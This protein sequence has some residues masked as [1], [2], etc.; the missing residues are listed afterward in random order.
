M[1]IEDV[2]AVNHKF[3]ISVACIMAIES[4]YLSFTVQCGAVCNHGLHHCMYSYIVI[5]LAYQCSNSFSP[6]IL[7][8]DLLEVYYCVGDLWR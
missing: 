7:L 4:Y 8:L 2:H 3:V 6:C 1:S 5:S